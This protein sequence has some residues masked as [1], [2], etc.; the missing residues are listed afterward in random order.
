[1]S[2]PFLQSYSPDAFYDDH[3]SP[4]GEGVFSGTLLFVEV[5][6]GAKIFSVKSIQRKG[7]YTKTLL[8][9][10][11]VVFMFEFLQGNKISQKW[12]YFVRDFC[13]LSH[14]KLLRMISK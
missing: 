12:K 10:K 8:L 1:M 5:R 7:L 11:R 9:I 4:G 3:G 13:S 6:F 14:L 2:F